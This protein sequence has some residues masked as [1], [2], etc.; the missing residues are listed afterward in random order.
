[1][2][3]DTFA[4]LAFSYEPA[5]SEYMKELPKKKDEKIINKYMVNQILVTGLYIFIVSILF[6]K[7]DFF[8]SMYRVDVTDKY[9]L[10]AFFGLFIFFTI[11]N[12]FNT[13]THR[14]KLLS[15]INKNKVFV[16]II[17][18]ILLIELL[19]IYYGGSLFRCTGLT[20]IEL[21]ITLLISLTVI[22]FDLFRKII[23]R[24]FSYK[25]G[26]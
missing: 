3:M 13:R 20:F 8:R 19:L 22:P 16:V 25:E 18:F 14:L 7:L 2:I 12:A 10:T 24:L 17:L 1:M 23:L 21:N 4:G 15:H 5:L 9:I 11:F 6:L 26:V